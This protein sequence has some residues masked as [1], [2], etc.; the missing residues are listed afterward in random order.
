[1]KSKQ[2]LISTGI[3]TTFFLVVYIVSASFTSPS[4]G[5]TTQDTTFHSLNEI[6]NLITTGTS[7]S[8]SLT[9]TS[10]S[11]TATTSHST[12]EIYLLLANTFKQ[13]NLRPGTN[14]FGITGAYGTPDPEYSVSTSSSYLSSITPTYEA[15]S[16]SMF[17]L[18]DI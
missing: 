11:P 8:H 15:N 13:E 12:T 4:S 7:T 14:L 18:M 2:F 1:M 6:Y 17:T 3:L 16:T 9:T 10:S 5:K